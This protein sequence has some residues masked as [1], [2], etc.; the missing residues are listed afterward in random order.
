LTKLYQTLSEELARAIRDGTLRVG[1]RAPSVRVLCHE[2][3]VS[4]ATVLRAYEV[5]ELDGLI[6]TRARSGYYVSA[7]WQQPV[8]GPQRA[9]AAARST[10]VDVSDLVFQTL[11]ALQD[12]NVVPLGSA[13][14]GP[15]LFPWAKLS[16]FL[17]SSARHMDPFETVESLPPGSL[18]LRRQ[19]AKRYLHGGVHVPLKEIIITNGA[20]EA[21]ILCLRSVTRPGDTI[22]VE[23]PTFYACLQAVENLGLKVVEI[24]THSGEGLDLA[25]LRLAI[26]RHDI[27]A[28]WFMTT[29]QNPSGTSMSEVRKQELVA[30]LTAHGIPLIEDDAYGELQ[31]RSQ[32]KP[33]KAFDQDGLVMHCGS[34]SK[35]L[36]PGYRLGWVAA[37]RQADAVRRLKITTSLGTS[38][39]VQL[40]IAQM[41]RQGGYDAHLV[42]LRATLAKQQE[43]ALAAI[44]RHFPSGYRV[45]PP[46]GGYFLWIQLPAGV[47]ALE[48]HRLALEDSISIAPGPIFSARRE[49][50]NYLRLNYGHPW[51]PQLD[52]AVA[53]L[54][55]LISSRMD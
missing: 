48:V 40:C 23:A 42:R 13:F 50:R 35:C 10:M 33:A 27:K 49:F 18:E 29:L 5:L 39:P 52:R 19:I 53:R 1:E 14:P 2:R 45:A 25:A 46:D 6:E 37:G 24:P 43:M 20:L 38:M 28:C 11:E 41:L 51:T 30:L 8:P 36:A 3:N 7:R 31:F 4:P 44:R 15:T 17:G 54:G 12:R 26:A 55:T 21:L 32:V 34:F 16:R 47:D 9:K 22:A